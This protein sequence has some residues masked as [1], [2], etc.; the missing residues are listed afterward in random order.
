MYMCISTAGSIAMLI[1]SIE[2]VNSYVFLHDT[3]DCKFRC[4][5]VRHMRLQIQMYF[6]TTHAIANSYVFLYDTCDCILLLD[7]KGK[8]HAIG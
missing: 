1:Y 6:S 8:L 5:S 7:Y 3:C 4:I 2:I